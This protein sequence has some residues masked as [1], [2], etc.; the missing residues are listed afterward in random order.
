MFLLLVNKFDEFFF[1]F[2]N[3]IA[4]SKLKQPAL[5][6]CGCINDFHIAVCSESLFLSASVEVCK[7][8]SSFVACSPLPSEICTCCN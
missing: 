5:F 4:P 8:E 6:M 7:L 3:C 2:L 1:F